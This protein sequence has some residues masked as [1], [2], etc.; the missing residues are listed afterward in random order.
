MTSGV[1]MHTM[2]RN[3][4]PDT[5]R[6]ARHT[7]VLDVDVQDSLEPLHPAHGQRRSRK[8]L[9][10]GWVS[11]VGDDVVALLEV[12]GEHAIAGRDTAAVGSQVPGTE[13]H[14]DRGRHH[15]EVTAR[16]VAG[17]HRRVSAGRSAETPVS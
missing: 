7:T 8:G 13:T 3:V 14:P 9:A 10:G 1:S 5:P 12:R 16:Y 6:A 15:S 4:P 2:T 11:R 17:V